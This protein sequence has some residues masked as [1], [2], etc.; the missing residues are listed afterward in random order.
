V[1]R[2]RSTPLALAAALIAITLSCSSSP[3]AE[4]PESGPCPVAAVPVGVSVDQWGDLVS[5]VAGRCGTVTTIISGSTADPHEFE[6]SPA[7]V[8]TIG[9]A[10]LVVVNG[11]GYDAWA[12]TAAG[13]ASP[14]PVVVEAAR[15]T[16]ARE[17]DN[18]HLWYSPRSVDLTVRA[19]S[20]ELRKL[21]PGADAYLDERLDALQRE[22][23]PYTEL[24]TAMRSRHAGR[25]YAATEPV[26]DLL[27]GALGL[28]DAR[29]LVVRRLAGRPAPAPRRRPGPGALG[30][31]PWT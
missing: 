30:R 28:T 14:P 31:S 25:S 23:V 6:A 1:I 7:D 5:R 27:A 19:V 8:A 15:T 22:L 9:A 3:A 4:G 18:P 29:R 17:G 11:L 10:R 26:F 13:Q 20:A 21:L 12:A 16:G 24:V 2:A